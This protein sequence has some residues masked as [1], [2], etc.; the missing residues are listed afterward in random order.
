MKE[1]IIERIKLLIQGKESSA[2]RFAENIGFNASTLNAYL[3]GERQRLNSDLLVRILNTYDDVSADWLLMGRGEWSRDI[4]SN[5]VSKSET[6]GIPLYDVAAAAGYGSF[7]SMISD[8]N[9]IDRYVVPD[10][11]CVDWMIHVQ[12][13]SMVPTYESGDIIACKMLHN[14]QE[15][16]WGNIYVVASQDKGLV[17]KRLFSSQTEEAILAVSDNEAFH[18]FDIRKE[19]ILGIASVVG[20]VRV[21]N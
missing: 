1:T 4:E 5:T 14:L 12:G 18:P 8:D 16:H 20:S 13:E 15:V 7:D 9:L 17:V 2:K 21:K 10:L 19:D 6:I 11:G 3:R